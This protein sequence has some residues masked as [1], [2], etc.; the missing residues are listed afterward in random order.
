MRPSPNSLPSFARGS[1]GNVSWSGRLAC[2][3]RRREPDHQRRSTGAGLPDALE[4]DSYQV[5]SP[6]TGSGHSGPRPPGVLVAVL[7]LPLV[8][9]ATLVPGPATTLGLR[10]AHTHAVLAYQAGSPGSGVLAA[11]WPARRAARLQVLDAIATV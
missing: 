1:T 7:G 2:L 4:R 8:P 5:I 3:R 10:R 11:L 9:A 6:T